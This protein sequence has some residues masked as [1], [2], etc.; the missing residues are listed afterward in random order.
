SVTAASAAS[1]RLSSAGEGGSKYNK[2]IP[3]AE[4]TQKQKKFLKSSFIKQLQILKPDQSSALP[5]ITM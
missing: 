3:Q 2:Q 1:Q 4:N 5:P